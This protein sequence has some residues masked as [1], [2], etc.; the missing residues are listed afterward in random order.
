LNIVKRVI[1]AQEVKDSHHWIATSPPPNEIEF[2]GERSGGDR[3]E[4]ETFHARVGGASYLPW[5]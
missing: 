2:S 1:S 3:A 4:T 5:L